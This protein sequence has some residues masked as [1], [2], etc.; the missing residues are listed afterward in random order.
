MKK[1]MNRDGNWD[2]RIRGMMLSQFE[3]SHVNSIVWEYG[4]AER[5]GASTALDNGNLLPFNTVLLAPFGVRHALV[6][7]HARLFISEWKMLIP[8]L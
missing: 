4:A 2:I 8:H 5:S 6:S 1:E 3:F 7:H